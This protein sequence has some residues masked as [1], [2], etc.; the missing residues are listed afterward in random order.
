MIRRKIKGLM[1]G[2][3]SGFMEVVV[4][5][6]LCLKDRKGCMIMPLECNEDTHLK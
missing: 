2:F 3:G 1:E 4:A 5:F 6:T